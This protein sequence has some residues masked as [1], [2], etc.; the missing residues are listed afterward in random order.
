VFSYIKKKFKNF[1]DSES[2]A[3]TVDWVVLTAGVVVL[4]SVLIQYTRTSILD[5]SDVVEA[6]VENPLRD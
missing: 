2:G 5:I 6:G 4:A 1:S 3:V